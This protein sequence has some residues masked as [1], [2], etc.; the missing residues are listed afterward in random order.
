MGQ[1]S[2]LGGHTGWGWGAG[3]LNS[4]RDRGTGDQA[5]LRGEGSGGPAGCACVHVCVHVCAFM[6]MP[7]GSVRERRASRKTLGPSLGD[8]RPGGITWKTE[9]IQPD[10]Q[11]PTRSAHILIRLG[12][13]PLPAG[14]SSGLVSFSCLRNAAGFHTSCSSWLF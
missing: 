10:H 14:F 9:T 5:P 13:L 2:C 4:K 1:L 8:Q 6:C 11:P 7:T 3:E 12:S